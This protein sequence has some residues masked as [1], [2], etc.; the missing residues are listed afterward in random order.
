[1]RLSRDWSSDVCSSDLIEPAIEPLGFDWKIGVGL[2]A[3]LA[4][5]EVIVATMGQIYAFGGEEDD[6]QGLGER[7]RS[8][9]DPETGEPVYGLRSEERRVGKWRMTVEV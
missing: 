2:V 8:E 4:A 1:T 6:V 9:T 7:M 5:R 3:S